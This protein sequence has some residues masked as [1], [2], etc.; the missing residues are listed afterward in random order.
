MYKEVDGI[1]AG[2][3]VRLLD[4]ETG[5]DGGPGT[6]RRKA[7]KQ[8][9]KSSK[10]WDKERAERGLPPWVGRGVGVLAVNEIRN[11]EIDPFRTNVLKSSKTLREWADEYCASDRKLKEFTYEKVCLSLHLFIISGNVD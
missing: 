7:T 5:H 4:T 9:K 11:P 2:E 8:E 6:G 10:G 1:F 3:G